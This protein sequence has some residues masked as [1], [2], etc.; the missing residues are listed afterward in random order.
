MVYRPYN[1]TQG[2]DYYGPALRPSKQQSTLWT[3][4]SP[5]PFYE[6]QNSS[7][8]AALGLGAAF[9]SGFIPT[10]GGGR[11]W[12][13]YTNLF[14][15][16]EEY[17]PGQVLRTFQIS[18]LTSQFTSQARR[19]F[20]YTGSELAQNKPL[21]EYLT[22]LIGERTA[23]GA[24][25]FEKLG[26]EGA[27]LRN[28]RFYF[29]K[30][31]VALKYASSLFSAE[32]ASQTF[33]KGYAWS[34]TNRGV[35][36]SDL[37]IAQQGVAGFNRQIIGANT[38]FGH[39]GRQ[40][41]GGGTY[42]VTRFNRLLEAPFEMEPFKTVFGKAQNLL[43]NVT[44]RQIQFAVK[45]GPGLK[46]LG[47]LSAKY[48]LGLG[49]ITLGYQTLDYLT[50]QSSFFDDTAFDEGLTHGL[51]T[52]GVK[53]N[54][55]AS[56]VAQYT[57]LHA[58]REAQESIA[59]GSTSLQSLV[60]FP[61]IGFLTGSTSVY[62][63]RIAKQMKYQRGGLTSAQ[64]GIKAAAD[65][66][67]FGKW[68]GS[69]EQLIAKK[70]GLYSR[71]DWIGKAIRKIATE[72]GEDI[73]YKFV[74]KIGPA[75][76]AGLIG[77]GLGAAAVLPFLPGALIPGTRPD[78]LEKIYSGQQEVAIRKGRWW[79]FGRSPFEGSR[80]M[81]FR[82]HWYARMSQ[83][84]REKS[85]YSEDTS[86]VERWWKTE[87]TY[88]FEKEHYYDRPYPITALPFEDVPLIGPLLA[89][90][91]GRLIKPPKLMHTE[92]W[93][94]D[95]GL[96]A[97]PPRFG[98]RI[99][100][101]IG[102]QSAPAPISP[103]DVRGT[104]GEQAYRF[105]EMVGLPGF[106]AT[107]IKEAITGTPDLYDQFSQLESARRAFG[108]E[109]AYWD[110]E[111]GGGLGTTEALRRLYPHRRRQIP[112]YNPI[113]NLMPEWL[114]GA[115][116]KSPDFLHGDPY[117]ISSDTLVEVLRHGFI[118]VDELR[119]SDWI[120]SHK[121]RWLPVKKIVKR[122]MNPHEQLFEIKVTS[123]AAFP[124]KASEEHPFWTPEGWVEAKDL[125]VGDYVGYPLG[126]SMSPVRI[127]KW[128]CD[129][130]PYLEESLPVVGEWIYMLG[131]LE[132]A[133]CVDFIEKNPGPY[134]N[135]KEILEKH[136]W[137]AKTFENA[138]RG[139]RKNTLKRF[140]AKFNMSSKEWGIVAGYYL[141]EGSITGDQLCFAF[142]QKE[143]EYHQE[144]IDA[145][146]TL[147]GVK[148]HVYPASN[149]NGCNVVFHNKILANFIP[150]ILGATFDKKRILSSEES[151]PDLLRCLFNGDGSFYF[152]QGKPRLSLKLKNLKLLWQVREILLNHYNCVA[153]INEDH[154]V[155]RG[156]AAKDLAMTLGTKYKEC[157]DSSRT[158][159]HTYIKDGYV[160]MRIFSKREVPQEPVYG[161]EVDHDDS[162]CVVGVA[163]HNTKVQEG[164]LR[165]PGEG[166]AARFSE[167][168]GVRPEDYPLIHQYKILAD[169]APY[170]DKF[171]Q[172][173]QAVRAAR[174]ADSWGEYEE[175]IYQTTQEQL[176]QR[177]VRKEFEEYQYL[178]PMGRIMDQQRYYGGEESSSL[179]AQI[180]KMKASEEPEVPGIFNRLFG[181][182]WELLAHN[183]E[184]AIDQLT[185]ISPGAK[186]VHTRT[187][188]EDYERTQVYGSENAFWQHP[189][190]DFLRPF[191][192]L[193]GKAF[194]FTD[195]PSHIKERRELEEYF[196][197]L[198][199]AKNA[200][201][202][203]LARM[204]GDA[205]AV[206]E[207]EKKKDETLFG[208]NPYT[209]NY[210]SVFRALPRR[211][212][213]YF[214]SFAEA[215]TTEERAKILEMVP[216]N[217][218]ALYIARW[219]MQLMDD[220]KKAKKSGILSDDQL[221][222][223]NQII[224]DTYSQ[225]K[226]E[227]FPTSKELFAEYVETRL[228]GET[229][230]DWYRRTKLLP[231]IPLPGPDW[232]GWHPS[233]DLEDIKLKVVQN[234]GEDMHDYDLW[235]SQA[236]TL[237]N[238][239][240]INDDAIHAIM[241]PEPLSDNEMERRVEQLLTP[242][243]I[244]ANVFTRNN[245]SGNNQLD[246]DMEQDINIQG[247]LSR[248][249]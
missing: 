180:N 66:K 67:Q 48:G 42:L 90:T 9:A 217:E 188:L 32:G 143:T 172:T 197:I 102:E 71:Q 238:K 19:G 209:F 191:I 20:G 190:R 106:A 50:R 228:E 96:A 245:L 104:I 159:R 137:S 36:F 153:Y 218:K 21:R 53:A 120:K 7:G 219:Q 216:E 148:G 27:F 161:I 1:L 184:T 239:P 105:T 77:A 141:S 103:Y 133:E 171:K 139:V 29:G 49:A 52:V 208:V 234:L 249:I 145:F 186:L 156:Q 68:S 28:G 100:T 163:T 59:P 175:N 26:R 34:A 248:I 93:M 72:D 98:G 167:L 165:L 121:G 135:R 69:I 70:S 38:F 45:E 241:E 206:K 195:I 155:I 152:D 201:L 207:F 174:K 94:G 181:G 130:E 233:V 212:R 14:R 189:W 30:G 214:N 177:K 182:Y 75:K 88:D 247:A 24:L 37:H 31:D 18:P 160:W 119:E 237:I 134:P 15:G 198:E 41:A 109:R 220:V 244:M 150:K 62:L 166:Y 8:L 79:E 25:T 146:E 17:S 115:G 231:Q 40:L 2:Q 243:G 64:A 223:A 202:S 110:L 6:G 58:Y 176:K 65:L 54:L 151:I 123:L 55:A 194:G 125:K 91:I 10:R 236:Q 87:F 162:F 116:E 82:P 56:R 164:E 232:V 44:G 83:R 61:M 118:K 47:R 85:L 144:L 138:Q 205:E 60:A 140:P 221:E 74:G 246:I 128:T 178:S 107:S 43:K 131:S 242:H 111:I 78:E 136:G 129:L 226:S 157:P 227:G 113:R 89:N 168:K 22:R 211:E 132:Y 80:I 97:M 154:L 200:R 222:E 12:D 204:S 192:Q 235:A 73:A 122:E 5:Q 240:Y 203:N 4:R 108:M 210:S 187:A 225:A 149:G 196:D 86:P 173:L 84:S 215:E 101:E 114:P 39:V 224:E 51:A 183:A 169:V 158:V 63:A 127:K 95:Q 185:P 142:H 230:P 16:I 126:N 33:G 46:M 147:W 11:M 229:Y 3:N 23:G 76:L 13:H 117:C 112:L 213:D 179:I 193:S 99:A 199:Y 57:G 124:I 170:S 35:G 81:Y 92:E